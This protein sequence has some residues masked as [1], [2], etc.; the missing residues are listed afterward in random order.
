VRTIPAAPTGLSFVDCL[1]PASEVLSRDLDDIVA[2]YAPL[3]FTDYL[4]RPQ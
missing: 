1:N 3:P 2:R 4:A